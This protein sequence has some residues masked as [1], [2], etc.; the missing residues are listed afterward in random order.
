MKKSKLQQRI[1]K[2]YYK[3]FPNQPIRE[4]ARTTSL[5]PSRVFRILNGHEM[6]L[7][8]YE[9]FESAI[10]KKEDEKSHTDF[11]QLSRNCFQRLS[12][13]KINN[14][15]EEMSFYLENESSQEIGVYA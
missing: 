1:L 14:L 6:K 11:F 7:S 9:L 8:E 15:I 5:H 3:T 4:V 13:N 10:L 2:D 12:I